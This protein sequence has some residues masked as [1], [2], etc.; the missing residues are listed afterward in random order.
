MS[1]RLISAIY[2][3][4][5]SLPTEENFYKEVLAEHDFISVAPQVY[6]LL[7]QQG[8]LDRT[9]LFFQ[10]QL[11]ERFNKAF[12]QNLFIKNQTKMILEKF[13]ELEINVIPLKGVFFSEKYFGHLGARATTDIDLLI[14][15]DDIQKVREVV[16]SLGFI[17][18]EKMIRNHFHCSFSKDIP[19]SP[20][21]LVVELHWNLLK[22][23]TANF[24]IREV[25]NNSNSINNSKYIK[26]LSKYHTFYFMCLHSWRHNFNSM[27][28]YLDIV[29]LIH[30]LCEE[31]DYFRLIN[32]GVQHKTSKRIIRTISLVYEEFQHLDRIKKFE[33]KRKFIVKKSDLKGIRKYVDVIDYQFLSYDSVKHGYREFLVWFKNECSVAIHH[34]IKNK[35][36]WLRR[37]RPFG[38]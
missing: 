5:T 1:S 20:V 37:T 12:Y 34:K 36:S 29:Q 22:E 7:N 6:H 18:E 8:K 16:K 9:P 10:N 38:S 33:L 21:P 31:I 30:S 14:H 24:D 2:D 32:D 13:E 26:E 25:W 3:P 19:S 4:F 28:Y 35:V 11:K 15:F 27:R 17:V 23:N